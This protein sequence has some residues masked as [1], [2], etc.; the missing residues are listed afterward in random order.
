MGNRTQVGLEATAEHRD[1]GVRM[2]VGRLMWAWTG[3][4]KC[5]PSELKSNV[6]NYIT[7]HCTLARDYYYYYYCYCYCCHAVV[8]LCVAGRHT[9][10]IQHLSVY[11]PDWVVG[12]QHYSECRSSSG[13][14]CLRLWDYR[15]HCTR[16]D[17]SS[18]SLAVTAVRVNNNN[19]IKTRR[20][21]QS[22]GPHRATA[23]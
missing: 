2:L 9:A 23:S 21:Q 19:D 22:W 3:N 13:R 16:L 12:V 6:Q 11:W 8:L 14:S 10:G 15:T 4:S 20:A 18:L 1:F 5:T 17:W 7:L